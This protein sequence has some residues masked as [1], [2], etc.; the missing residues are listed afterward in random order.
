MAD[1]WMKNPDIAARIEELKAQSSAKC[2][3]FL[4]K[5]ARD[6]QSCPSA[7]LL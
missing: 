6:F 7:F 4:L 2:S 1:Q 3:L 5:T